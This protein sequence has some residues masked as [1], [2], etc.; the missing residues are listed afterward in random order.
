M[1][2]TKLTKRIDSRK[3]PMCSVLCHGDVDFTN[4]VVECAQQEHACTF[5]E[6]ASQKE[7]NVKRHMKRA[8]KGLLEDSIPLGGVADKIGQ[9]REEDN[10]NRDDVDNTDDHVSDSG[11]EDWISQDPGELLE[12]SHEMPS[13][14]VENPLKKG[15]EVL[16]APRESDLLAGR[17]F[18]KKTKPSLPGKRVHPQDDHSLVTSQAVDETAKMSTMTQTS[19]CFLDDKLKADVGTQTDFATEI[20]KKTIWKFR[21]GDIDIEE[22]TEEKLILY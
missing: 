6:F 20:S 15:G 5:C 22:I 10:L 4:H 19:G 14:V 8:H 3:C 2:K 16:D 17:V 11:D 12:E 13:T 18:R 9:K 21:Q 1:V 7:C